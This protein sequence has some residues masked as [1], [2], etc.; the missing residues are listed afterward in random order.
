M[1]LASVETLI[2]TCFVSLAQGIFDFSSNA[3]TAMG[4]IR[5]FIFTCPNVSFRMISFRGNVYV[6]FYHSK[7]NFISGN[8]T[9]K[10]R[11]SQ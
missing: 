6:T 11:H 4:I 10:K 5:F 8:M 9:T 7:Q 1:L 2:G 3:A